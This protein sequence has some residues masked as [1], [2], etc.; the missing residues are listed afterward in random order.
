MPEECSGAR[1]RFCQCESRVIVEFEKHLSQTSTPPTPMITQPLFPDEL[2]DSKVF[3]VL[4]L[5]QVFP[6]GC[7]SSSCILFFF[8]LCSFRCYLERPPTI[9][10][11]VSAGRRHASKP[12]T[13]EEKDSRRAKTDLSEHERPQSRR[14]RGKLS[15]ISTAFETTPARRG[16]RQL[17]C[18]VLL[19]YLC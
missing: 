5:W 9:Q 2:V 4:P 14:R 8:P 3:H 16:Q 10:E 11:N 19:L 18:F 13:N 1:F 15:P 6:H 17:F 7:S 12:N